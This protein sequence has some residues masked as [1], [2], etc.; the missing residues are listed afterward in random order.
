MVQTLT[1]AEADELV[2]LVNDWLA[3]DDSFGT[4]L[5]VEY[6]RGIIHVESEEDRGDDPPYPLSARAE[7]ERVCGS[8]ATWLRAYLRDRLRATDGLTCTGNV[9]AYSGAEYSPNGLVIFRHGEGDGEA[10]WSIAAWAQYDVA[11]LAPEIAGANTEHVRTSLRRLA[12]TRCK[13]EPNRHE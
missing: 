13:G 9:C 7:A 6:R 4:G 11:A 1:D 5:S 8:A 12:G 2:T 3:S 10:D